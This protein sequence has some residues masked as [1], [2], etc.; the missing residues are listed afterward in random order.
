MSEDEGKLIADVRNG[1][2]SVSWTADGKVAFI[3]CDDGSAKEIYFG[4][5][6]EAPYVKRTLY[7]SAEYSGIALLKGDGKFL[8]EV[9]GNGRVSIYEMTTPWDLS[10]RFF[11]PDLTRLQPN[12]GM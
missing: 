11:R 8:A 9:D 5:W 12:G 1:K 6:N 2:P 3:Q 7:F 10:T 4:D